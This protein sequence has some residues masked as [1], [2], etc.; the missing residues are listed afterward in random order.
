[1]TNA[2]LH[3]KNPGTCSLVWLQTM[4]QVQAEEWCFVD[5]FSRSEVD[6]WQHWFQKFVLLCGLN[7]S[8]RSQWSVFPKSVQATKNY[9]SGQKLIFLIWYDTYRLVSC[10]AEEKTT[11]YCKIWQNLPLFTLDKNWGRYCFFAAIMTKNHTS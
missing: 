7:L 5:G 9:W 10:Y 6:Q 11:F 3:G 4:L 2:F 1:M 8:Y